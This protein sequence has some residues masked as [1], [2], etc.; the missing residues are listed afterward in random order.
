MGVRILAA[1]LGSCLAMAVSGA[2]A[3]DA[4]AVLKRRL[5][6]EKVL[7]DYAGGNRTAVS[8]AIQGRLDSTT[9]V[10]LMQFARDQKALWK[11]ARAAFMLEAAVSLDRTGG[12]SGSS[13]AVDLVRSGYR[14][15]IARPAAIGTNPAEDRFEVMF[16]QIGLAL[17]QGLADWGLHDDY[18]SDI[19]PRMVKMWQVNPALPSRFA[20]TRAVNATFQCCNNL[21]PP[22]AGQMVVI[23]GF[24]NRSS[25]P[26]AVHRPEE[27][28][29]LFEAAAAIPALRAEALLRSAYLDWLRGRF[30]PALVTLDRAGSMADDV[31]A[32]AAA[33]IR[34]G[35]LDGLGRPADAAAAYAVAQRL[36]PGTQ[37]PVIGRA[38]ALHR[39]GLTDEALAEAN[40]AR[41]L[42]VGHDDPWPT[43][44]RI[45][46]RYIWQWLQE[47]RTL[48]S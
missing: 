30:E 6:L 43:F 39:A 14:F 33:L 31:F 8:R 10:A 36:A 46:A 34:A 15:V 9:R 45:D 41:H 20:L 12:G 23:T 25:K 32:Y 35:S 24:G 37:V 13:T 18:V 22:I 29:A 42:P 21:I 27:A 16:H 40:R 2:G 7:E 28:T 3:Q 38:A 47:L 48:F 17:L 5:E 26:P 44:L 4:S 19:T 1:C 11:P